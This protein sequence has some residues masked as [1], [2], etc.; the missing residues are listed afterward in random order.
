LRD[1]SLSFWET[2]NVFS[3]VIPAYTEDG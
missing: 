2:L 3:D 1:Y